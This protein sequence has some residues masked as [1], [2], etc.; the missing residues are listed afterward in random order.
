[1]ER[2]KFIASQG[3]EAS[4][5]GAGIELPGPSI[6][7]CPFEVGD[8]IAYRPPHG[9]AMRVTSRV[10]RPANEK[11]EAEWAVFVEEVPNPIPANPPRS[12]E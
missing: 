12:L 8:V 4:L 10:Y 1:M 6:T 2:I 9:L 3:L 5:I 7:P 11:H